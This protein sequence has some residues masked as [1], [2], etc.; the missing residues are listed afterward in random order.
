MSGARAR[1][2]PSDPDQEKSRVILS[3]YIKNPVSSMK[4]DFFDSFVCKPGSVL[5]GH[6][7]SLAVTDKLRRFRAVP[8]GDMRRADHLHAV[9]LRIGFTA[10]VRYRTSG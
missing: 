7:S 2:R 9:L 3:E 8:P 6:Q 1:R 10:N 4:R 5:N